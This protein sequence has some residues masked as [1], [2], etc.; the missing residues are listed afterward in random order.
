MPSSLSPQERSLRARKAAYI[1]AAKYDGREVTA[2][3]RSM[4]PASVEYWLP[5]VEGG[6]DL[7]ESERLRRAEA[8]KKAWYTDLAFKSAQARRKGKP[9]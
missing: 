7:P 2:K 4:G 6:D 1:R 8:L 5:K 9:A 3:A